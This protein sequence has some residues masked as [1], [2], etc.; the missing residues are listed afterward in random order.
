M[1]NTFGKARGQRSTAT[2]S[3]AHTYTDTVAHIVGIGGWFERNIYVEQ[4][5]NYINVNNVLVKFHV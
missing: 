1:V 2:S 4:K 5:W 3:A